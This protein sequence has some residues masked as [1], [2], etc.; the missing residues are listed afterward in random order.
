M[1][2]KGYLILGIFSFLCWTAVCV[3]ATTWFMQEKKRYDFN[4]SSSVISDDPAKYPFL[5]KELSDYIC[6][7][8]DEMKVD[9]DL[10]VAHLMEENPEYEPLA[11]HRNENGTVDCGLFQL[12]DR[13]IWT[14]FKNRYWFE[15]IEL[16]PFNWKCNT[17]IAVHHIQWLQKKLKVTDDAI[18]AYNCGEGPVMNG[19]IPAATI[20]YRARVKNNI[21]LLKHREVE[22]AN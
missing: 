2:K 10:V 20:S 6:E 4:I 5:G 15:D 8:C 11:M 1:K 17:Y 9:S 12:N 13:Y 22:N 14:T 16:D 19:T 7:L 3:I 18:A 21:W